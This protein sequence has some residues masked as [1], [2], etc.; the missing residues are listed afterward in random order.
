MMT[1]VIDDTRESTMSKATFRTGKL[2][3]STKSK[4]ATKSKAVVEVQKKPFKV[5]IRKLPVRDF[6]RS[7]FT[8]AIS[9]IAQHF[10]TS[11]VS[12]SAAAITAADKEIIQIEHF[13]EG[14]LRCGAVVNHISTSK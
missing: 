3:D 7:A 12:D 4:G 6:N 11:N 5:V 13:I 1:D 8:A 10:S 14:K 9:R 2:K